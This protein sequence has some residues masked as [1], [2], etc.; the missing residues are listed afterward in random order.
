MSRR[1]LIL[2][3]AQS[4]ATAIASKADPATIMSHFPESS[5]AFAH[6]YGPSPVTSSIP[7]LGKTFEGYQ[8]IEKYMSLLG[9]LLEYENMEFFDYT[10]AEEEE[11]VTVKGRANWTYV[12]TAKKWDETFI[13]RLSRF[14]EEGKIGGYEVWADPLSLW[15]ATQEKE[16]EK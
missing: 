8:G 2:A 10:V 6:E 12:K 3:K 15:W 13:W 7:F 4:L 16:G 9:E 5:K 1:K 14:D 11:V